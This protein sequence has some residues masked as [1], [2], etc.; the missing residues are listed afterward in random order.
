MLTTTPL[1][2][3]SGFASQTQPHLPPHDA[4]QSVILT[5][6]GSHGVFDISFALPEG[7]PGFFGMTVVG[8]DGTL[9]VADESKDGEG[10]FK[11]ILNKGTSKGEETVLAWEPKVGVQKELESFYDAF[12][13]KDDGKG[14]PKNALQDVAIIQA[15][16][17]SNGAPIDIQQLISGA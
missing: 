8:K 2:T 15:S 13:G 6:G 9:T 5:E 3:L 11:V 10:A 4:L 17:T 7:A 12:K 14:Q 1:K 16:L